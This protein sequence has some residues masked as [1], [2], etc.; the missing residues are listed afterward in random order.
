MAENESNFKWIAIILAA[1][2]S[3]RMG[4]PKQFLK[5]DN[6][7]LIEKAANA[8][9]DAGAGE[10]IVVA[11]LDHDLIKTE[12]RRIPIQVIVNPHSEMGIGNSLKFGMDFVIKNFSDYDA[13]VIMVCDQP[14]VTS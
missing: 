9:L 2:S 1:G 12:L 5:I 4:K 13:A 11:G 6:E 3:S 7:T 8:A 14:L 10:T